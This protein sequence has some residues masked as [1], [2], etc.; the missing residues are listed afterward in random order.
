VFYFFALCKDADP[1]IPHPEASQNGVREAAVDG[2]VC[3]PTAGA[4]TVATRR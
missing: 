3:H 1:D 4:V 2:G